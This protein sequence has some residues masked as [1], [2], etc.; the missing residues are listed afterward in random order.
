MP[1]SQKSDEPQPAPV[2]RKALLIGVGLDAKDDHVRITKGENF[3]LVGGT[4]ETHSRMT[5]TAIKVNEKLQKRG[6]QLEDVSRE[7]FTDLLRESAQ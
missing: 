3:R 7:E 6:R 2:Q 5:E 4:E 1:Y